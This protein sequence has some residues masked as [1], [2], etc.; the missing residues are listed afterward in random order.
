MKVVRITALWC[1]SCLVMKGRY[2]KVFKNYGISD[3]VDLDYDLD[4]VDTYK[5]GH[6]LPIVI[7][8]DQG[9]EIK[10]IVGE[11]SKKTLTKIFDEIVD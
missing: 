7:I 6:I 4:Q 1:M 3:V 8:Y 2:N 9:H 10:R 5:P 11:Q